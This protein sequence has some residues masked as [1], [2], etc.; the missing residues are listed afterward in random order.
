MH[1]RSRPGEESG[2]KGRLGKKLGKKLVTKHFKIGQ[3]PLKDV[4]R[5]L[6]NISLSFKWIQRIS[7]QTRMAEM[8]LKIPCPSRDVPVRF[9]PSAPFFP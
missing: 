3:N 2:G 9:R 4:G 6:N 1:S 8:G 7:K 5:L